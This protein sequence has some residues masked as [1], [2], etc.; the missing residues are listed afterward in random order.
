M[1]VEAL[2]EKGFCLML[3]LFSHINAHI[4]SRPHSI[5]WTSSDTLTVLSRARLGSL[6]WQNLGS[7]EV[8]DPGNSCFS[9]A[10]LYSPQ[11]LALPSWN[12]GQ[13]LSPTPVSIFQKTGNAVRAIGR[14]S[15][16]AMISGLS[17]RKSSTGSPTSPL[18]AEKLESE[19]KEEFLQPAGE[20]ERVGEQ[21][22]ILRFWLVL[23]FFFFFLIFFLICP[24]K[25]NS[26]VIL[27]CPD[28]Y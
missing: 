2:Y 28:S 26:E 20:K 24:A 5:L 6:L 15:S 25:I 9:G 3:T 27:S 14:L 17:G 4:S 23:F 1:G 7:R 18:N 11:P 22:G 16:M 8:L 19:G 13:R 10:G 12:Q 21:R